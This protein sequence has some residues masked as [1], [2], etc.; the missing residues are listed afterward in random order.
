MYKKIIEEFP[1]IEFIASGGI[2]NMDDVD[3]LFNLGCHGVI[4]G[5]AIYE[6]KI[7]LSNLK[8]WENKRNNNNLIC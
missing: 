8:D 1:N 6:N 2:S 7:S 5:K 4:I 3:K